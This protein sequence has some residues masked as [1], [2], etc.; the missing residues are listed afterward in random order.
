MESELKKVDYDNQDIS[1]TDKHP[2]LHELSDVTE[3]NDE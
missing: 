2:S 3:E 1:S